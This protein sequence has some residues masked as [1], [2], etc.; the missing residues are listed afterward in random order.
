MIEP[1]QDEGSAKALVWALAF[2]VVGVIVLLVIF[3]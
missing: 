3:L 1:M 2:G